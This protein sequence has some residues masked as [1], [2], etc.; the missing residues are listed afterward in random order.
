MA[1]R[2]GHEWAA[3]RRPVARPLG[4]PV[5]S[6]KGWP[7]VPSFRQRSATLGWD[8]SQFHCDSS[9]TGSDM[10]EPRGLCFT[11]RIAPVDAKTTT[12]GDAS[13]NGDLTP[14]TAIPVGSVSIPWKSDRTI[15]CSP[16]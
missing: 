11:A 10:K 9:F 5:A 2:C 3:L 8:S 15:D 13:R 4:V 16:Y 12:C 1:R 7:L 6:L 14:R